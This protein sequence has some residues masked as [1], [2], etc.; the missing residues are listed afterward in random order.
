MKYGETDVDTVGTA[1]VI[2]SLV[3]IVIEYCQFY[4][5]F[6]LLILQNQS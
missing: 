5:I 3:N 2:N 4:V 1:L 6:K